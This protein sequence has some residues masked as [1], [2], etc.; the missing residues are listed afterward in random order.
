MSTDDAHGPS[1][2]DNDIDPADVRAELDRQRTRT[3][4]TEFDDALVEL[5]SCV[6]DTDTRTRIYIHLR[7]RPHS[8]VEEIA[9]GTGLYPS[10][11]RTVLS[12]LHDE[13]VVE[14]CTRMQDTEDSAEYTAIRP[15]EL[16][17][18]VFGQV[19]DELDSFFDRL[20]GRTNRERRDT[21]PVTIPVEEADE[22][23]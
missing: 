16:V 17:E 5:L 19:Q 21:E 7:R 20:L 8:T 11:V 3:D 23:D 9:E 22:E 18:V 6:L 10:T 4:D 1:E 15:N 12:D 13:G 2:E 14:R